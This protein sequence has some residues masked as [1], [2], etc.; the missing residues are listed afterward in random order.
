MTKLTRKPQA[1]IGHVSGGDPPA[2]DGHGL[3]K[4]YGR[5]TVV[6]NLDMTVPTGVVAGFLGPNGAGKTTT[7]RMLLGL[8]R[9][10]AGDARVLGV[11]LTEPSGYLGRVGALIESPAFYPG[12]SGERNLA[13]QAIL[14]GLDLA[15]IPAVL[16]RVGLEGRGADRYKTYSLGMKQRL[17]IAAALL[18]QP[19]LLVLDEPT[20]GLDPTGIREMRILLGS[21]ADDGP[22]VLVSSHLLSEVQ[23]M[24]DW[25]IAIDHGRRVFQ[26]PTAQLLSAGGDELVLGCQH[27]SDVP[28]LVA[29]LDRRGLHAMPDGDRLRVRVSHD[30]ASADNAVQAALAEINQAAMDEQITLVELTV[31]RATL[32]DRYLALMSKSGGTS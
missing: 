16:E 19:D 12:L 14:G 24:C 18:G 28:R 11:A 29:L 8:V 15:Q 23:Q 25:L 30:P 3:T 22:T 31:A 6:D 4:R 1:V 26:G 27:L 21:L 13:V 10:D 2:V 20:N 17:G 9:P 5:R 7:L 32:E